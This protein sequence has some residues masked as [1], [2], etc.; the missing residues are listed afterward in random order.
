MIKKTQFVFFFLFFKT[1][2]KICNLLFSRKKKLQLVF[3]KTI[4]KNNNKTKTQQKYSEFH[5]LLYTFD[6]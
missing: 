1:A 5:S 6:H 2:S 4:L 3:P